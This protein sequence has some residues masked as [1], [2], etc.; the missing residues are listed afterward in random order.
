MVKRFYTD[1]GEKIATVTTAQMK[2]VDRIAVEETGPN[3]FQMME[4]AGRNLAMTVIDMI[5][6]NAN[7]SIII[8]AGTG[9]NGGGGIASA[10]H[11]LNR[12]YNV[13]I[14]VTDK[15]GLKDVPKRQLEIFENAGG[16]LIENLNDIKAD[17]IVDAIIGYNLSNAPKGKSLQFIEWA[18]SQKAEKISLDIPSGVDATTGESYGK[19]VNTNSTLTLALPKTGL[20]KEKSG[21]LLLGDIGIPKIVYDKVG[22][23]YHSPFEDRFIVPLKFKK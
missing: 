10:R 9:G 6:K 3:L 12:N 19:Y 14:A 21:N 8:L 7:P 5:E 15:S 22:I 11:L 16:I 4:N 2:E 17:I 1:K 18:N 23:E 13:S 20:L